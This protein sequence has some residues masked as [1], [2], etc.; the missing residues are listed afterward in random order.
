MTGSATAAARAVLMDAP[1]PLEDV[2]PFVAVA[3]DRCTS[4]VSARRAI[5]AE[6]ASGLLLIED[7]GDD[8][9]T[10]LLAG[11]ADEARALRAR[12]RCADRAATR[13]RRDR[14]AALPPY[15]E[16]RLLTEA[17]LLVDWYTPAVLG[18]PLPDAARDEY[19]GALAR[20][21]AARGAAGSRPW[22]CATIMSTI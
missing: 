18:A 15:D 19:L 14:T 11:G 7:F 21:A 10:R 22:C 9:Y 3:R 13:S 8:T 4:S 16:A 12:D 1:P 6:D 17:S 2:R 5:Y 20:G